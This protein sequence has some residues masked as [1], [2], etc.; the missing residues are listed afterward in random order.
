MGNLSQPNLGEYAAR[1]HTLSLLPQHV[2]HDGLLP[3]LPKNLLP[4]D[5]SSDISPG[6]DSQAKAIVEL[7]STFWS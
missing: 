4:I 1:A 2:S 6:G 5:Q 7:E 3:G